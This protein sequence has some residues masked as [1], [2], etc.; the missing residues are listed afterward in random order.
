MISKEEL[1]ILEARGLELIQPYVTQHSRM[2]TEKLKKFVLDYCNENIWTDMDVPPDMV[3]MVFLPLLFGGLQ[4][5][6]ETVEKLE[7]IL[8]PKP[9]DEPQMPEKPK[10]PDLDSYPP[11]IPDFKEIIPDPNRLEQLKSNIGWELTL[12]ETV[13]EYLKD[14]QVQNTLEKEKHEQ[15]VENRNEKCRLIDAKWESEMHLWGKACKKYDQQVANLAQEKET[16]ADTNARRDAVMKGLSKGWT[17]DF[18]IIWAYASE[19]GPRCVNGY[20]IFMSCRIMGKADWA[21]AKEA[22]IKELDR[23]KNFTL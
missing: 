9:G 12:Q 6:K 21:I 8:P 11:E 20:P 22:I 10:K 3:G 18:A 19:A 14:I 4:I 23:R 7:P 5:P 13:D 15:E 16:W 1:E 17:N 2:S